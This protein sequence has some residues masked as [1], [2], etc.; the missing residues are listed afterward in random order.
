MTQ[1][2][3]PEA[4][5]PDP[6]TEQALRGLMRD[7]RYWDASRRDPAFQRLVTRGFELLYPE[8]ARHDATGRLIPSAPRA[9]RL[10][11]LEQ[12][13]RALRGEE[14]GGPGGGAVHVSAH[15]RHQGSQVVQVDDYTRAAPGQGSQGAKPEQPTLASKDKIDAITKAGSWVGESRHCVALVKHALPSLGNTANWKPGQAIKAN[16][17]P[18]LEYG[19]PIATF[20]TKGVYE[21]KSTGNHAAIFLESTEN[22]IKVLDQARDDKPQKREIRFNQP[23]AHSASNRAEAFSVILPRK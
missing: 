19:T 1:R 9:G 6:L 10:A 18:P 4:G 13:R 22:G 21:N 12:G 3:M 23:A 8:P 15:Q 16:D 5:L 2:L 7:P 20:N 14:G 17:N 11:D